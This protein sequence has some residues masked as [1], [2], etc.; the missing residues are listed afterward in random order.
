M[1]E[2]ALAPHIYDKVN[3]AIVI[4]GSAR[5]GT[6]I[7]G[8]LLHSMEGVEYI[9]EPP[10][11]YC[12]MPM[13]DVLDGASWRLFYEAYLYEDFLVN[14]LAGR[15]INCN[16][17]DDSSIYNC[18][19]VDLINKRLDY[20]F[21][22]I[23]TQE[24]A[25]HSTIAYKMPFIVPYLPK[26]REYY[27]G[28]RIVV[29][30]RNAVDVIYSIRTMGWFKDEVLFDQNLLWPYRIQG[31]MKAPFFVRKADV[32]RWCQMDEVNRI[33]YYYIRMYEG[34][35]K[36]SDLTVVHYEDLVADPAE[37]V[38]K[39]RERLG[40]RS[41]AMTDE[42]IN[43]VK[44]RKYEDRV[45]GILDELKPKYLEKIKSVSDIIKQ[46]SI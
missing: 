15:T 2:L 8:K 16:R 37:R 24:L 10:M 27:P 45:P 11:L 14:A 13:I 21:S 26:I 44:L 43:S 5:S 32:E 7:L 34:L 41:G 18:K 23:E 4:S 40:L 29:I 38:M 1:S 31:D 35:E 3:Q 12:L 39:L 22:K 30:A 42:I 46:Y 19:S 25:R 33:A 17:R 28:T 20:S 6:T 9:L 36:I